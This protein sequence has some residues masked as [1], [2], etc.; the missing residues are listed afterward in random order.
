MLLPLR[1]HIMNL[2]QRL[3]ALCDELIRPALTAGERKRIERRLRVS[4]L[5]LRHY[6]KAFELERKDE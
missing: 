5:A 3:Q 2:E 4:E 1:D 6:V